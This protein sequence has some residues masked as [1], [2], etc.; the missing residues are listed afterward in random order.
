VIRPLERRDLPEV[1]RL[2]QRV[3]R[4]AE[5]LDQAETVAFF[6]RTLLDHP[7]A[8]PEIPSLVHI[9]DE[10]RIAGFLGSHV[11]RLLFDGQPIRAGYVGHLMAAPD[12]RPRGMVGTLLLRRYLAGPQD[13]SLTDTA[14]EPTRRMWE[15]LGGR[16]L[17]VRT[18][19]WTR[20]FRP[21][22]L[23]ADRLSNGLPTVARFVGRVSPVLDRASART[24]RGLLATSPPA[25]T[26]EPLTTEA[27]LRELP[28]LLKGTRLRP[29]YD[30]PFVDW[31]FAELD[32]L[33][34]GRRCV[35]RLVSDA[36]GTALGWYVYLLAPGGVS[37]VLELAAPGAS[38]EP[39]LVDLLHHARVSGSAALHGRLEPSL[40]QPLSGKRAP[41]TY[42]GGA[43]AHSERHDLLD[44]LDAPD[45]L[46]TRMDGEWWSSPPD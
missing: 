33:G 6:E 36:E 15:G 40:P 41:L 28:T 31:L 19:G 32:R 12:S 1:A 23:A 34:P 35:R 13:A 7:W 17:P 42:R 27:L 46:L 45:S 38:I 43:L 11:R 16:L 39:V 24:A 30:E 8:D 22:E 5:V 26:S 29:A 37:H 4:Q 25:A 21:W 20:V 44:A 10:G 9:Q 2:F 18:I 14:G 3:M